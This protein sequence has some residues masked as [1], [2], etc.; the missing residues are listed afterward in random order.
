M[1]LDGPGPAYAPERPLAV[2]R[3]EATSE[4]AQRLAR[5][6][7][8]LAERQVADVEAILRDL[9]SGYLSLRGAAW[10]IVHGAHQ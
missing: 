9:Q 3:P 10:R 6:E 5:I 2:K 4:V 8:I 1:M 7:A